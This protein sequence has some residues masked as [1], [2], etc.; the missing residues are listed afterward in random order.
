MIFFASYFFFLMESAKSSMFSPG[1][2]VDDARGLLVAA[3][4]WIPIIKK[5]IK[6]LDTGYPH[7]ERTNKW[8]VPLLS[9]VVVLQKHRKKNIS[10][11]DLSPIEAE[12]RIYASVIKPSLV[13]IICANAGILL[14]ARLRINFSEIVIKIHAFHSRKCTRKCRSRNGGHLSRPQCVSNSISTCVSRQM[15]GYAYLA[16][17]IS[18]V[19]IQWHRINFQDLISFRYWRFKKVLLLRINIRCIGIVIILSNVGKDTWGMY[20]FDIGH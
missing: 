16:R 3:L 14:I 17:C 12:W 20:L 6:L 4:V 8:N 13:Q 1:K 10:A 2:H 5:Y 9:L 15:L 7:N 18:N 19:E 11:K